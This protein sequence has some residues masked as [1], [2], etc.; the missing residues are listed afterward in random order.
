MSYFSV[1]TG[2]VAIALSGILAKWTPIP[3]E[4]SAFWRM[5]IAAA[6]LLPWWLRHRPAQLPIPAAALATLA[7]VFF[8]ADI[9]LFHI[10]LQIT[11]VANATLLAHVAPFWVALGALVLFRERLPLTFWLGMAMAVAG[12]VLVM[13]A[14]VTRLAPGSGDALAITASLFYA[15]YLVTT[16]RARIRLPAPTVF[17]LSLTG[18]VAVLLPLCFV[19]RT[20]LTGYDGRTWALLVAL[21]LVPQLGGWFAIS[22]ALGH[23]RATVMSVSL[24]GQPVLTALLG[25]P[26]LGEY[27]SVRQI[28][29]GLMV[30]AG[31]YVVS[32]RGQH[33]PPGGATLGAHA[34]R[35]TESPSPPY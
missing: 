25:V 10:A 30:L 18:S 17:M 3:G 8:G 23:L 29:G 16:E 6:V 22:Y 9:A 20:P 28:L 5:L 31:I 15:G 4:A 14:G 26:L 32:Q 1:S 12:V 24:L 13:S 11:S 19:L 7:G 35:L 34:R 27:L 33:L 21:A 2:V